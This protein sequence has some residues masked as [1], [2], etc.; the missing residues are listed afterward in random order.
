MSQTIYKS[1]ADRKSFVKQ[2]SIPSFSHVI[3]VII[4]F[5]I[6]SFTALPGAAKADTSFY[7]ISPAI[8]SNEL[9]EFS[10]DS[11]TNEVIEVTNTL[12]LTLNG[13]ESDFYTN[14]IAFSP[15]GELYGWSLMNKD[16]NETSGQLYTIDT[17]SGE[18]NLIGSAQGDEFINGLAFDSN[19]TLYGLGTNL[20]TINTSTGIETQIGS[21]PI[22]DGNRG[23][24][25]DS[26]DQ[27]YAWTGSQIAEDQLIMIDETTGDTTNIQLDLDIQSCCV[28]TEFNPDTGEIVTIRGGNMIYSTDI[29]TGHVS[30]LGSVEYNGVAINANSLAAV[31]VVPEPISTILFL[32]GGAVFAGRH[33]RNKKR[34][35]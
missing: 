6:F 3:I 19:G 28:G 17:S 24:A 21:D 35:A 16:T 23:L 29:T 33:Y 14:S 18:I 15:T 13:E 26:S 2:R 5:L 32:T 27:L 12:T 8:G 4:M 31:A 22:G 25:I 30:Y 1:N 7:A 10:L 20:Y 9:L 11:I 34:T